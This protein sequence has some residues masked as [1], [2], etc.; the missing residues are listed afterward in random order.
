MSLSDYKF[1]SGVTGHYRSLQDGRTLAV[2]P[3]SKDLAVLYFIE[4]NGIPCILPSGITVNDE[5]FLPNNKHV[6]ELD[7]A[8]CYTI[9]YED[10]LL[11]DGEYKVSE[12]F[13]F[14]DN[15]VP[16]YTT[17]IT[18]SAKAGENVITVSSTRGIEIG[19]I[20]SSNAFEDDL[21]VV[22]VDSESNMVA[23]DMPPSETFSNA[24]IFVN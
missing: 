16:L 2:Q 1:V 15:R 14:P 8:K 6:M 5:P 23:V 7:M 21:T 19:S 24:T 12:Y 3:T 18:A 10:Q 9:V 17:L 13:E 4:S 20:I 11:M 22:D